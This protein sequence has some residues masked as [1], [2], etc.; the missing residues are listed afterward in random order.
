M[1]AYDYWVKRGRIYRSEDA[2][3]LIRYSDPDCREE[4]NRKLQE[5]RPQNLKEVTEGE[6]KFAELLDEMPIKYRRELPIPGRRTIYFADF[7]IR[8]PYFLVV[9]IDGGVHKKQEDY[10]SFRDSE[11]MAITGWPILRF[12]NQQVVENDEDMWETFFGA[13]FEILNLEK[14]RRDTR[15]QWS[16]YIYKN[17]MTKYCPNLARRTFKTDLHINKYQ[18]KKADKA[19]DNDAFISMLSEQILSTPLKNESLEAD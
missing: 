16:N 15:A 19:L 17:F 1:S 6:K 3:K 11:I 18:R 10:D 9:E 2:F 7:L 5:Y 8:C 4:M 14:Y 12:T 13:L